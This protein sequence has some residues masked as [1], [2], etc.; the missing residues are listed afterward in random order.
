MVLHRKCENHD[1]EGLSSI[2]QKEQGS[3]VAVTRGNPTVTFF[4]HHTGQCLWQRMAGV[5]M[6]Q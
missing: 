2:E 6:R 1:I 3:Q 5:N 4:K